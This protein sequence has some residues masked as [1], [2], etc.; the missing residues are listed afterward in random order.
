MT[1]VSQI[2]VGRHKTGIVGLDE[3]LKESCIQSP[4]KQTAIAVRGGTGESIYQSDESV[5]R[6]QPCQND[7][8]A[9]SSPSLRM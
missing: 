5:V 8:D 2:K 6:S 4:I 3:G 9:S 1:K 7:E